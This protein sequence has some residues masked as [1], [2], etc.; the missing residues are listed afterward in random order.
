MISQRTIELPDLTVIDH[1]FEGSASGCAMPMT[2]AMILPCGFV[3]ALFSGKAR[4]SVRGLGLGLGLG[5]RG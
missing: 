5:R 2:A 4:S 1:T 3:N